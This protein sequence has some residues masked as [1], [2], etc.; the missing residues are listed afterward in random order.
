MRKADTE[1][2]TESPHPERRIPPQY[3]NQK[4]RCPRDIALEN[5]LE[6]RADFEIVLNG[7]GLIGEE[8]LSILPKQSTTYE[9]IFSPLRAM[10]EVGSVA[11]IH[12]KLGEIWYELELNAEAP[13]PIRLP[14]LKCELGKVATHIVELENPSAKDVKVKSK[15][16]NIANFELDVQE[17]VIPKYTSIEVVIRYL[18]SELDVVETAEIVFETEEIRNWTYLAFGQ[19][20]P[21]NPFDP[22]IIHGMLNKDSS[23]TI[24][25]R[26]PFKEQISVG[27][28]LRGEG[29]SMDVFEIL[30]KKSRVA[31]GP[32]N[33]LQIPVSFLPRA[34]DKIKW[35][36]PIRGVTESLSTGG[37]FHLK[38]KCR[39]RERE[40]DQI[41]R[42]GNRTSRKS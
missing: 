1:I 28:E 41:I 34:N 19:G 37:D 31:I 40:R 35:V 5:P 10:K 15:I 42:D 32:L 24:N 27:L 22:Q 18:P 2:R 39:E 11:F 16:S 26:N 23:A 7:E 14:T 3:P 6:E 38:T 36:F 8:T 21:P 33:V 4:G 20:I 13:Q 17:I 30:L 12:E 25:F 29:D 9:L